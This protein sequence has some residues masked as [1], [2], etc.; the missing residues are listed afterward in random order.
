MLAIGAIGFI[1]PVGLLAPYFEYLFSIGSFF[2]L[3]RILKA[4]F[5]GG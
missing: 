4:S 2:D 3:A 5:L 1:A